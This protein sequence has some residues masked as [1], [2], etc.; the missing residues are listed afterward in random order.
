[1]GLE[2]LRAESLKC[3][4]NCFTEETTIWLVMRGGRH[5]T[6]GAQTKAASEDGLEEQS[7]ILHQPR[8]GELNQALI[9]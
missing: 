1:M 9:F 8:S 5:E 2:G 3:C 4:L 6:R 7:S